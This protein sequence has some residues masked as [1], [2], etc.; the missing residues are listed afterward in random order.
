MEKSASAGRGVR[1]AG[2]LLGDSRDM[3]CGEES[4]AGGLFSNLMLIS[5]KRLPSG[6]TDLALP[7]VRLTPGGQP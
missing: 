7:R 1:S 2:H 5:F 3:G 4:T 6:F